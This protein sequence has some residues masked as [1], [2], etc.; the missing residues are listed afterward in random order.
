MQGE[1]VSLSLDTVGARIKSIRGSLSQ[2]DFAA[3]LGVDRKSVVGWEGDKRLPDGATLLRLAVEFGADLNHLLLGGSESKRL[4]ADEEVM[5]SY[6]REATPE[7]R[8]AA[9]GALIGAQPGNQAAP[10][11][12]SK[13]VNKAPGVL[14]VGQIT[15]TGK[16]RVI[17]K[18][19]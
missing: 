9:L 5:L 16:A 3:R 7:V 8:K 2:A 17:N 1:F 19:G 10:A 12:P 18:K 13:M 14:Q 4:A 6:Y 11:T 15:G